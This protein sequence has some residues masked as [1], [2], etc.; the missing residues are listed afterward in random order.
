MLEISD[1]SDK[2]ECVFEFTKES[3]KNTNE[4]MPSET[5]CSNF[6]QGPQVS[7]LDEQ[8]IGNI[9]KR[10]KIFLLLL[11]HWFM[12]GLAVFHNQVLSPG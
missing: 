11:T 10:A 7:D 9:M 3:Q 12:L 6:C 8:I 2:W 1:F 5:F 4:Y